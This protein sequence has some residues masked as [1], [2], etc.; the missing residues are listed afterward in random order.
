M[1]LF[2]E[3]SAEFGFVVEKLKSVPADKLPHILAIINEAV[4][5]AK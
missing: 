1:I 4:E 2:G 5:C 3:T